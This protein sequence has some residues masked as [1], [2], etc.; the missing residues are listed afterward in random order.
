MRG[1]RGVLVWGLPVVLVI[2]V[3]VGAVGWYARR[4]Y[5]VGLSADRVTVF[6]GVPGGLLGWQPTVDRRTE[7][8]AADLTEADRADLQNGHRFASRTDA[9]GFVARLEQAHEAMAG[10]TTGTATAPPGEGAPAPV[11]TST[12]PAAGPPET[13]R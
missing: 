10:M 8:T 6:R 2:G 3:G 13:T 5:Y 11:T 9:D 7:L 12:G 4:T 1:L